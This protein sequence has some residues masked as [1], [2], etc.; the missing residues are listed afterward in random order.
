MNA[1]TRIDYAAVVAIAVVAGAMHLQAQHVIDRDGTLDLTTITVEELTALRPPLASDQ[2]ASLSFTN[3]DLLHGTPVLI[4]PRHTN[5]AWRSVASE[6]V[7]DFSLDGIDKIAFPR[8]QAR[9][10]SLADNIVYL[11]NGDRFGGT[12]VSMGDRVL[13]IETSFAGRMNVPSL[14]VERILSGRPGEHT[15]Y[16]GP[17]SLDGWTPAPNAPRLAW[18]YRA[19]ALRTQQTQGI[20]RIIEGLPDVFRLSFDAAWASGPTFSVFI[21]SDNVGDYLTSCYMIQISGTRTSIRRLG[22]AIRIST[23][24][25]AAAQQLTSKKQANFTLLVDRAQGTFDLIID[26]IHTAR[27]HDPQDFAGKGNGIMFK[28]DR[29]LRGELALSDIHVSRWSGQFPE[30][31]TPRPAS[32]NDLLYFLNGDAIEGE[33]IGIEGSDFRFRT[34]YGEIDIPGRRVTELILGATARRKA[35]R[36]PHEVRVVLG[37][38]G[39]RLTLALEQLKD[40]LLSA[41]SE[42]TGNLQIDT[43]YLAAL[44]FHVKH[45]DKPFIVTLTAR[46]DC[47][48][49][50]HV[51]REA[52]VQWVRKTRPPNR[53]KPTPADLAPFLKK[54]WDELRCPA[55]GRYELGDGTTPPTCNIPDHRLP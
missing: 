28:L 1:W 15:L 30:A 38:D 26:D 32:T 31:L 49:N 29:H 16:E 55:G 25:S 34:S 3:G 33:L 40:G 9:Q 44:E 17:V 37:R 41:S 54:P 53:A 46:S 50:L 21:G 45:D 4:A 11:T 27:W 13:K 19:G 10:H 39:G 24:G 35:Y 36:R 6:D 8:P 43:R 47:I 23:L 42:N 52:V 14:F 22:R 18:T 7:I 2:H 5:L 51:L 20:G 48:A 12:L